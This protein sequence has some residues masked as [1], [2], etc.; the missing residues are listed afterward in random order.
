MLAWIIERCKGGAHAVEKPLGS[1]PS[2]DALDFSGLGLDEATITELLAVDSAAWRRET[3]EIGR[4]LESYGERL[5]AG[6]REEVARL[7]ARL[8]S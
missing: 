4:Y 6:L 8:T 7:K 5:P 1:V 2:R 3:D